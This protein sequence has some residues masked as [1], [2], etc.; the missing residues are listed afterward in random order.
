[1]ARLHRRQNDIPSSPSVPGERWLNFRLSK[2]DPSE[3][4]TVVVKESRVRW[5]LQKWRT[6]VLVLAYLAIMTNFI[7]PLELYLRQYR[8]INDDANAQWSFGQ[9]SGSGKNF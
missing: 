2:G 7:P 9:V 5:R 1:M 8:Q 6:A 4:T 3:Y